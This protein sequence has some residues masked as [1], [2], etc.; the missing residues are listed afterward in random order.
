MTEN[1]FLLVRSSY[2][3]ATYG[4]GIQV[5]KSA[6]NLNIY[7]LTLAKARHDRTFYL[8]EILCIIK[9]IILCILTNSNLIPCPWVFLQMQTH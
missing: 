9:I 8:E 7:I 3:N 5:H 6:S 2:T 1:S 4:R